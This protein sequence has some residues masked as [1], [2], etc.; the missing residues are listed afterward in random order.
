MTLS[1]A[2]RY[3]LGWLAIA[4]GLAFLLWLLGPVL[5]PFV[6]ALVIGYILEPAVSMLV[7][8]RV[9]RVLAV[10][11]V[12]VMAG[13]LTVALALLVVPILSKE[14]P[15]LREQLPLLLDKS[16]AWLA[17]NLA[18]LGV[19]VALDAES[20]KTFVFEH[21]S[22]N[23]EAW[24]TTV[25]SSARAGGGFVLGL[26]GALVLLPV[27][28]FYLLMDWPLFV[29]RTAALVPPRFRPAV[30][31]FVSEC[32]HMLGQYLRGQLLVMGVLA[33]Y[34]SLGLAI[35][36][37]DL[38]VPV[39]VF[40]GLAVFIPYVGFGLGLVMAVLTALLQFDG[41]YGLVAV[42]IVYG[43]GQ[44]VESV[45]LTPRLVGERI[46]LHPVV[47]IFALLAFGQFFGFIGVLIAL[48]VT[49]VAAVAW[50]RLKAL[51]LGSPLF[52]G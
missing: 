13:L 50:Q 38:A 34:Y 29:A 35:A 12:V 45:W 17:P 14:L 16:I 47:V 23:A 20:L 33:A 32:D 3:G 7:R 19:D 31:G 49:A 22:A 41:W 44:V 2:Q 18:R 46:G 39:G 5:A 1:P 51:Y 40:T 30:D 43:I 36:G 10:T 25:L 21:V 6:V 52:R 37:F 26:V 4:A 24:M 9:P 11:V 42:A 15:A 28:L 27:V 8:R 48:P